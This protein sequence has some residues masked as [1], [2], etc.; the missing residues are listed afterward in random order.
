MHRERVND[1]QPI[2]PRIKDNNNNNFTDDS[3]EEEYIDP[4]EEMHWVKHETELFI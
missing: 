1:Y 2:H 4:H 3:F